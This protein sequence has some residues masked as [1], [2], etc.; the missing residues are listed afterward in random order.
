M[1]FVLLRSS[2]KKCF[3]AKTLQ[4]FPCQKHF[5]SFGI[6]NCAIFLSGWTQND[7]FLADDIGSTNKKQMFSVF[8]SNFL[9]WVAPINSIG[10]CWKLWESRVKRLGP[11]ILALWHK[12]KTVSAIVSGCYQSHYNE[13]NTYQPTGLKKEMAGN[14]G[15]HIIT[16]K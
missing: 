5:Q 6:I 15:Y 11:E 12:M 14:I 1:E 2:Y 13:W 8:F 3:L 10:V 9:G 7:N 4:K 16:K